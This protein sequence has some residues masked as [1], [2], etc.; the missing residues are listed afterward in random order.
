MQLSTN[1]DK[2]KMLYFNT[3]LARI[4]IAFE[5]R[6]FIVVVLKN[7]TFSTSKNL[8]LGHM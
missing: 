7:L 5:V 8:L 4:F 2:K 6:V 3:R 1:K